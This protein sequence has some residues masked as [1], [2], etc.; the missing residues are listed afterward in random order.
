MTHTPSADRWQLMAAPGRRW[1]RLSLL[2]KLL[3]PTAL[4]LLLITVTLSAINYQSSRQNIIDAENRQLE[5]AY[6]DYLAYLA[7]QSEHALALAMQIAN[8]PTAQAAVADRDRDALMAAFFDTYTALNAAFD[9]PQ[10]QFHIPPATS[11][12]RLHDPESPQDDLSGFRFT[13]LDTNINRQ[14]TYGIEVGRGGPGIRGVVPVTHNGQHVGSF[15]IGMN[16]TATSLQQMQT[17][18]GGDWHLYLDA[19][20]A[21]IA[22]LTGFRIE[23]AGPV[24]GLLSFASTGGDF[25]PVAAADYDSVLMTSQPHIT[26]LNNNN[27]DAYAVFVAPLQDYRGHT[28][29]LLQIDMNRNAVV[30]QIVATQ[31][32]TLGLGLGMSVVMLFLLWWVIHRALTPVHKLTQPPKP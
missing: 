29:G 13:V 24:E 15:E 32:Q 1:N 21:A 8:Q 7:A 16:I 2:A 20:A 9:I 11:L 22:T 28:I 5:A 14:P 31:V 27:G 25:L 3:V 18:H 6:Q 4:T 17:I 23:A 30:A 10:A 26:R 12:L 19:N